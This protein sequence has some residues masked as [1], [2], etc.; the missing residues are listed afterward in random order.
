MKKFVIMMMALVVLLGITSSAYAHS[1]RL[2]K[3]GGHNC[4]AKSKQKGLCT[5]Y[6]YHKKKR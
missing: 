5:G 3:N 6:H 4:S 1:G 2:D